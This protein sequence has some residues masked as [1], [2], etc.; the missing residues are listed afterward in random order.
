MTTIYHQVGIKAPIEKVFDAISTLEGVSGWWTLTTG[1]PT[2]HGQLTFSFGEHDVFAKVTAYEDN[3]YLEWT[4]QTKEG[5]EWLDTR[6][7]FDLD[8][9]QDQIMVNFQHADWKQ[10]TNF[11][12]HC[13]TKW[14]VF[15][16]SLK[17]YV[18]TGKGM[19][20][21]DDI[22]INHSTF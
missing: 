20:F 1:D 5:D 19:S 11:L 15:M 8:E 3:K 7:C 4:I 17:E 2:L 21:P 22:H 18:E 10:P 9:Q 13:S 14:G 16:V 6:L 12:S